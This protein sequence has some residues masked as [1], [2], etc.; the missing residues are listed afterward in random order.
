MKPDILVKGGDYAP[1]EIVGGLEVLN[2]GGIVKSLRFHEGYSTTE[3]EQKI[4]ASYKN[5]TS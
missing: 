5:R 3:I 2:H 1:D 4:I